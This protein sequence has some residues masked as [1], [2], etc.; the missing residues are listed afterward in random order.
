[1]KNTEFEKQIQARVTA[2]VEDISR[3]V[4]TAAFEA[5]GEALGGF[6][7]QAPSS[8]K[9]AP[10]RT[11]D[12]NTEIVVEAG[13]VMPVASARSRSST[14]RSRR[15]PEDLEALGARVLQHLANHPGS[16]MENIAAAVGESTKELQRPMQLLLAS[17]AVTSQG[18]KRA[19]EYTLS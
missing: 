17:G 9:T 16:R 2:F 13:V 18:Q 10:R 14:R 11:R 7:T 12:E 8:A 19:T 5:I 3:L 4:Q 6:G 15:T 1:M